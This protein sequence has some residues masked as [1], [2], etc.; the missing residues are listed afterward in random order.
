MAID[1]QQTA[2]D[3]LR[4]QGARCI[5]LLKALQS[6]ARNLAIR[7]SQNDPVGT[8]VAVIRYN[9]ACDDR[10]SE[11]DEVAGVLRGDRDLQNICDGR[12]NLGQAVAALRDRLQLIKPIAKEFDDLE[13]RI[14]LSITGVDRSPAELA[15]A[16]DSALELGAIAMESKPPP[17]DETLFD[18]WVRAAKNNPL[19]AGLMIVVVA[20]TAVLAIPGFN[21]LVSSFGASPPP[22]VAGWVEAGRLRHGDP[23]HWSSRELDVVAD[24]DAPDRPY[25]VRTGDIV[26]LQEPLPAWVVGF[27][28]HGDSHLTSAP[29]L[30]AWTSRAGNLTGTAFAAHTR[31]MVQDVHVMP[32]PGGDDV[33][34]VRLGSP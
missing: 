25:P 19:T 27:S 4:E 10:V 26:V 20:L 22:A 1:D 33:L 30:R 8:R 3:A 5:E 7:A 11:N 21:H 29:D 18:R 17:T 32:V 24:S 12:W 28:A 9:Q 15:D 13:R 2:F 23:Q 16:I 6:P 34:W 14:R 31:L